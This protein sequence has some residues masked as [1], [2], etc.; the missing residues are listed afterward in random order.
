MNE[1]VNKRVIEF[2]KKAK[3]QGNTLKPTYV[4]RHRTSLDRMIKTKEQAAK[5][6]K[7]LHN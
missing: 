1:N 2:I 5:F 6:M 4:V 3:L 7:L